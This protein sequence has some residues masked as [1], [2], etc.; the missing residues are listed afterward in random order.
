LRETVTYNEETLFV[1][2]LVCRCI[3]VTVYLTPQ[4]KQS[5]PYNTEAQLLAPTD[6]TKQLYRSS[7]L[8]LTTIQPRITL[9]ECFSNSIHAY[10][11]RPERT[12]SVEQTHTT[13]TLWNRNRTQVHVDAASYSPS[14]LRNNQ[15]QSTE[16]LFSIH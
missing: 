2:L 9:Q 4:N 6:L 12:L 13:V 14:L 15:R 11:R 7:G 5:L 1:F 16:F 3:E 10:K 8:K